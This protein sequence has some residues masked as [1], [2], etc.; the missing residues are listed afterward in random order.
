MHWDNP[1]KLK[2]E[3]KKDLHQLRE[4]LAQR[5]GVTKVSYPKAVEYLLYKEL[6][7]K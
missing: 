3:V 6:Q 1:I 5:W 4:I 7:E 2:P